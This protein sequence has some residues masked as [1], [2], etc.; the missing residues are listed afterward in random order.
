MKHV[1]ITVAVVAGSGARVGNAGRV[2]SA[3]CGRCSAWRLADDQSRSRGEP[4]LAVEAD[5]HQQRVIAERGVDVPPGRRRHVS[6][7]RHQRRDV[8]LERDRVVAL[9][10][11]TGKEIWAHSLQPVAAPAPAPPPS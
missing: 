4:L 2:C 3:Q 1:G 7:A 11:E 8:R 9:D 10:G 5:Q 6:A